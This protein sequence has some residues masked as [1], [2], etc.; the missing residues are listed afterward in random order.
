MVFGTR[1]CFNDLSLLFLP[2]RGK[3]FR[4][5]DAKVNYNWFALIACMNILS[6]HWEALLFIISWQLHNLLIGMSEETAKNSVGYYT[7][8]NFHVAAS[9]HEFK[10]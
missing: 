8:D 5:Q 4:K 9:L 6:V 7:V 1:R 10:M 3:L 2:V